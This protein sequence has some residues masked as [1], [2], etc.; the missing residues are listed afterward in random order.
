MLLPND[1]SEI[2]FALFDQSAELGGRVTQQLLQIADKFIDKTFTVN[3]RNHIAVI[4]ISQRAAQFFIIHGG[5]VLTCSPQL[6][7]SFRLI[8]LKFTLSAHPSYGVS[9]APISQ[10]FKE[11]LPELNLPA[12]DGATRGCHE[13][14][15]R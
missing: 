10:Q 3:F 11:K 6:R 9:V 7:D 14:C 8:E 13:G 15:V 2:S 4:I 5:L 12:V 1:S